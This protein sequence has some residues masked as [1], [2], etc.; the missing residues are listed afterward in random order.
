MILIYGFASS[1]I[2]T[3]KFI[4][5]PR[6]NTARNTFET[7]FPQKKLCGCKKAMELFSIPLS[8]VYFALFRLRPISSAIS[9]ETCGAAIE[10]PFSFLNWLPGHVDKISTPGAFVFAPLPRELNEASLPD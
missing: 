4:N 10:V 5:N 9:P 2:M 7:F 1:K 6:N 3:P 8:F